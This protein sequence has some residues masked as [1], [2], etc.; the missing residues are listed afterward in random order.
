MSE[1]KLDTYKRVHFAVMAI[2]ASAR[3]AHLTGW[4]IHDRLKRQDLIHKRLMRHYDQLHTQSLSWVA[5]DTLE[6]LKNWEREVQF[7]DSVI[8]EIKEEE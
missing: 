3:K 2:E 7:V 6:T 8:V 1:K 4:E 5:D